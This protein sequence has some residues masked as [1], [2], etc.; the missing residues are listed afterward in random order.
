MCRP[1][2]EDV[3]FEVCPEKFAPVGKDYKNRD[4]LK[5]SALE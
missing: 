4:M 1:F 2:F 3:F 5:F